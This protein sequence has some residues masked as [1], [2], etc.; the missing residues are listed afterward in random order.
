MS[1]C[2]TESLSSS[3]QPM[4]CPY[5]EWCKTAKYLF[6]HIY[7]THYDEIYTSVGSLTKLKDEYDRDFLPKL[8]LTWEESEEEY[9]EGVTTVK[10][11]VKQR[12][13][14]CCFGCSKTFFTSNS[15][16]SHLTKGTKKSDCY[17]DHKNLVK[18]I[19][20]MLE[21]NEPKETDPYTWI[22]TY[23]IDEIRKG[24]ERYGRGIVY[25]QNVI[26]YNLKTARFDM[27]YLQGKRFTDFT[28]INPADIR[29][30]KSLIEAY[31]TNAKMALEMIKF[32]T[33]YRLVD[34]YNCLDLPHNL[35]NH[36]ERKDNNDLPEFAGVGDVKKVVEVVNT[37]TPDPRARV[38]S[39]PSIAE[40]KPR[41]SSFTNEAFRG[42]VSIITR[43]PSFTGAS[44]TNLPKILT[45]TKRS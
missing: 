37:I 45:S 34:K 15:V 19:L 35:C 8:N 16:Q 6:K 39:L 7:A 12:D 24:A 43:R 17:K 1:I 22:Y 11:V 25:M 31:K 21:Y 27:K 44:Q 18:R 33:D 40:E 14:W 28:P 38:E 30:K 5:C 36:E 10:Q 9:D 2:S 20:A 13:V 42:E 29:N 3:N 41:R 26:D 4:K 23:P 32:I